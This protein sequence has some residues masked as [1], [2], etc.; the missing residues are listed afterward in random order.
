[1]CYACII[2]F[3]Y[4]YSF[5]KPEETLDYHI[6]KAWHNI[7]R[8]YNAEAARYQ[9]TMS[10]G[11]VLLNIDQHEGTPSTKLGPKM[12]MEPRSLTRTLKTMEE[13]GLISRKNSKNDKRSVRIFLTEKGKKKRE[14]ARSKVVLLNEKLQ[15]KLGK[16]KVK[17][18][19]GTLTKIDELLTDFEFKN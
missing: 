11:F 4:I 8:I 5:M 1:M 7:A 15:T 16:T 3:Y 17:E 12:G 6:R 14:I 13:E 10:V 19:I 18:F 2:F 9:L